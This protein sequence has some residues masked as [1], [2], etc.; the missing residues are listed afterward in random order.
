MQ[1]MSSRI[2]KNLRF[3]AGMAAGRYDLTLRAHA[4]LRGMGDRLVQADTELCIEGYQRSANS[5]FYRVVRRCNRQLRIAHHL[6]A[7]AQLKRAIRYGIP[8]VALIRNP[9]DTLTSLLTSDPRLSVDLAV[10]TYIRFLQDLKPLADNLVVASFD[11]AI[12]RP[13]TIIAALNQRFGCQ[14]QGADISQQQLHRLKQRLHQGSAQRAFA[15]VPNALKEKRKSALR[16]RIEDHPRL[17]VAQ[18]AFDELGKH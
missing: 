16:P 2:V 5:Y 6:H 15:P 13:G 1:A 9:S 11:Q 14:L 18:Q 10:S 17:A 7:V 12:N 3:A 4:M 8:A